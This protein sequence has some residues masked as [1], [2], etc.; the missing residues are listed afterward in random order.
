MSAIK[1]TTNR[2]ILSRWCS[3]CFTL[4]K[5][6]SSQLNIFKQSRTKTFQFPIKNVHD[7]LNVSL[8]LLTFPSLEQSHMTVETWESVQINAQ[9]GETDE[10]VDSLTVCMWDQMVESLHVV[11]FHHYFV[12]LNR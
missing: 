5:A 7:F 6:S 4:Q 2:L 1:P 12:T 8:I 10:K 11:L 9:E 3:A